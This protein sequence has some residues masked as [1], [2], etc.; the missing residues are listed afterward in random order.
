MRSYSWRCSQRG[1]SSS[2]EMIVFK[3][4]FKSPENLI[5][6]TR[7]QMEQYDQAVEKRN[8]TGP[9]EVKTSIGTTV[10]WKKPPFGVLK[11]NWDAALDP[12]TSKMG[13]GI[14]ARDHEGRVLAMTSSTRNQI[15]HP[16]TVETLVAWQAVV[17][18][19]Q[20]RATCMELEGDASEVVQV[21]IYQIIV[22]EEMVQS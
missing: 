13:L 5:Q 15:S 9:L 1:K 17:L 20:L 3:G 8:K 11:I 14:L 6:A 10:R 12:R 22:G 4:E 7:T 21:S 19:V 18:G 2:G 16:T